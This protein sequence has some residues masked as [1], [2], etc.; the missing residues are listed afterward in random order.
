MTYVKKNIDIIL[1]LVK[2]FEW[3]T[4]IV[5]LEKCLRSC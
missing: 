5:Q 2:E 4:W 3:D 1:D